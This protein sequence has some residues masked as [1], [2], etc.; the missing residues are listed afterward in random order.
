VRPRSRMRPGK[1][2]LS[3]VKGAKN[4]AAASESS[5]P[6]TT[7]SQVEAD[8]TGG[9]LAEVVSLAWPE[10][11]A[12]APPTMEGPYTSEDTLTEHTFTRSLAFWLHR[13]SVSPDAKTPN[14]SPTVIAPQTTA[15]P[16]S[17]PLA[18]VQLDFDDQGDGAQVSSQA[19][20][21]CASFAPAQ[22]D[23]DSQGDG[24]EVSF[25]DGESSA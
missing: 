18:P 3:D 21:A 10:T 4:Q 16:V 2:A 14:P 20:F 15:A 17:A 11:S 8:K 12:P 22:P 6:A 24:A 1:P 9:P 5:L 25:Q 13:D 19:T 7:T 23:L